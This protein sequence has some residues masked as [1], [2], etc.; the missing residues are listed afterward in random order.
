MASKA[1][2]T[3][4]ENRFFTLANVRALAKVLRQFELTELELDSG[5]ERLRLRRE[6]GGT[7]P[8]LTAQSTQGA[9]STPQTN[10]QVEAAAQAVEE[11]DDGTVQITSPFVG[12]FYRASSPE[13]PPFVESG[14]TAKKGQVL[15]IVEAMKLMNE[16]EAETDCRIVDVV[17]RNA[18]PVEFGQTLF[19]VFPL[20]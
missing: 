13:S 17:A 3:R 20:A 12:T 16:I 18:E 5:G 9:A 2:R 7:V 6:S 14:Q 10:S 4:D 11:T 19:K 1:T 8:V 15:C